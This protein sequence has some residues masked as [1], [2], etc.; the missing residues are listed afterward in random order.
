MASKK[1]QKGKAMSLADFHAT[2]PQ[3]ND[4]NINVS[5]GGSTRINWADEME[6]LDD[7]STATMEIANIRSQLPTAPKATLEPDFNIELLPKRPPFTAHLSNVSFEADEEKIRAFFK[8]LKIVNVRL[9]VD[10][11]NRTRGYGYVEFVDRESLIAALTKKDTVFNNRPIKISLDEPK[12]GGYG[13]RQG[14][15]DRGGDRGGAQHDGP[16]KSDEA[17]W[18]R[19]SEPESE[20]TNS[21]SMAGGRDQQRGGGGGGGYMQRGQQERGDYSSYNQNRRFGE[22]G[23][24]QGRGGYQ[25]RG[26]GYT[27]RG[28][29]GGGGGGGAWS[30]GRRDGGQDNNDGGRR[31]HTSGGGGYGQHKSYGGDFSQRDRTHVEP[32]ND[33]S[34]WKTQPAGAPEP[35]EVSHKEPT[36][37]AAPVADASPTTSTTEIKERPKISI[38]PR[39]IPVGEAAAAA[40]PVVSASSIFGSAKPVN[41]AAREKEIEER[42]KK[43]RELIAA[44]KKKEAE[45][46]TTSTTESAHSAEQHDTSHDGAVSESHRSHKTSFTSDDGR[47]HAVSPQQQHHH[48]QHRSPKEQE[49]QTVSGR[50][51]R[52]TRD[53]RDH[54]QR[55][56]RDHR[57]HRGGG[58]EHRDHN[59]PHQQ[60]QQQQQPN[61]MPQSSSF[62]HKPAPSPQQQQQ[63][64]HQQQRQPP[65]DLVEAPRPA[66]NAWVTKP[67]AELFN[68]DQMQSTEPT[69]TGR[70]YLN[71]TNASSTNI[72]PA[73]REGANED[74]RPFNNNKSSNF[75]QHNRPNRDGGGGGGGGDR[76]PNNNSAGAGGDRKFS[77]NQRNDRQPNDRNPSGNFNNSRKSGASTTTGGSDRQQFNANYEN[78]NKNNVVAEPENSVGII[79]N[80]FA[81]LQVDVDD[82]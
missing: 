32:K 48:Q 8:D 4:T 56:N 80:K 35:Q 21:W 47:H 78:F 7:D 71:N 49:F 16:L 44:E 14:G 17:D 40:A 77:K 50:Q 20:S 2:V 52:D 29:G 22:G 63:Q 70:S 18:R 79:N 59:K 33:E 3:A 34:P 60:Q 68:K 58:G 65:K 30:G 15:G 73:N 51:K 1:K 45:K 76:R 9:P 62:Q 28:G 57:E 53:N 27:Q 37:V 61:R 36:V 41:T 46:Q 72:K 69:D 82:F 25:R 11:R 10:E 43:E 24:Q 64:Q 54:H 26:E 42:L 81:N 67:A 6:K 75:T 38:A 31:Q 23:Q 55:D 39:S 19:P 12:A 13:G 5:S 74:R 66:V